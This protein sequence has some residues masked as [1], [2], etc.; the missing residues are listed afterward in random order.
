[1]A[2]LRGRV[3]SDIAQYEADASEDLIEQVR[4]SMCS[5]RALGGSGLGDA[6]QRGNNRKERQRAIGEGE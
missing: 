5:A 1:M 3:L 2:A 4:R 6:L